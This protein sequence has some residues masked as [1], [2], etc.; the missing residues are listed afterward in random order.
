[1]R[2]ASPSS[3]VSVNTFRVAHLPDV[4]GASLERGS[5]SAG[6]GGRSDGALAHGRILHSFTFL[7]APFCFSESFQLR[8]SA[9]LNGP[10]CPLAVRYR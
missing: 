5:V 10:N 7:H 3:C 9:R 6:G 1:M 4:R 2:T 8:K